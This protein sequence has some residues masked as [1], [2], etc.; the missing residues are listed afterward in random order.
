MET[1][2]TYYLFKLPDGTRKTLD[3]HLDPDSLQLVDH[4]PD[5]LPNWTR[6][7]FK[8]CPHCPLQPE[9][10]PRCP[11]AAS[12]VGLI[13][14]SQELL[15]H[16]KVEVTVVTPERSVR[17]ETTAQR[18]L[19]AVM[20]L[21]SATSGCPHTQYMKPMARFHLPFANEEETIYRAASMYLLAQYFRRLLGREADLDLDGLVDIY[22]ALQ[23][24]NQSM[25]ERLRAASEQD[26]ATN[27]LV[28]LD[29]FAR[30]MPYSVE[31]S[32]EEVRYVFSA[33]LQ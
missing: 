30:A 3:L 14:L 21:I 20:G 28:L 17:A 1:F 5:E 31:D 9:Q 16:D 26:A 23:Q 6:L 11:L 29:L 12:L 18:G 4:L 33:Y 32:L 22:Q 2:N 13:S 7:D 10:S 25:I 19:S 15:S 8:Q 27:A 24:V